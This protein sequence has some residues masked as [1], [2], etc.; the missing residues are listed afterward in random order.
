M[1][2]MS[3]LYVP[4][5]LSAVIVFVASSIVHMVLPWHKSDFRSVPD[6]DKVLDALRPFNL[7]PG[8]YMLPKPQSMADLKSPDFKQKLERGPKVVMTV[9]PNGAGGMGTSLV[10]WFIYLLVVSAFSGYIAGRALP[11]GAN[12]LQV[13][14]FAGASAFLAYSLA[15][16]Q[17]SIW[18]RRSWTITIKSTIDGLLFALLTAG[19]FGWLWP[20]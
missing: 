5:V 2:G 18:W 17:M 9:M 19:T 7:A 14:R 16:W 12:Y 10:Q 4:I 20:R 1:V 13:F 3:G 6:E 15:L 11:A 8:D